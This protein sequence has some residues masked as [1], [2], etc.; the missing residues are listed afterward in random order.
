MHVAGLQIFQLPKG[1]GSNWLQELINEQRSRRPGV[2]FSQRLAPGMLGRMQLVED[3]E[4]DI[5]YHVRHNV[6]PKPGNDEQLSAAIARMHSNLLDRDR[7]LWEFH[8]IEGLSNRR[9][10]FYIKI[11]HAICDGAT[12]SN[13]MADATE[14]TARGKIRA[15]WERSHRPSSHAVSPF[16]QAMQSPGDTLRKSAELGLGLGRYTAQLL[17]ERVIEGNE[18][19]ALPMSGSHTALNAHVSASRNLAMSQAPLKELKA[20]GKKVGGT[21]ND[22]VL[23]ICDAALRRYLGEQGEEPEKPLLAAVPV[24]L[25]KEGDNSEG[26]FVTSLLVKLGS[27]QQSPEE[28]LRT[29][30]QSVRVARTVCED[31]PTSATQVVSFGSGLLGAVGSALR[32]EGIMP[33][34]LNLVIS[35]VRGPAGVRYFGG[36]KLLATYPISGIAPMTVLNVT[37]YSYN[38]TV[39][40]GMV[41]GRRALPHLRDLKLCLDEIYE[42]YAKALLTN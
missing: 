6:L 9:F 1:K 2:P 33:P 13:W 30:S 26:N 27:P 8:L 11:H 36:A 23:A 7:P 20:M 34:P 15:I 41:S 18:L 4:F 40:F 3:K 10:A 42:E 12:F 14:S 19:V 37:V 24:N 16:V 38:D 39:F 25:R 35:N 31:V 22:V 21:L 32:L 29:V 5:D 17:K 28:R